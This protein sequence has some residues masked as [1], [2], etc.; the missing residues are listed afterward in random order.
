MA[1]GAARIHSC[2]D[3]LTSTSIF[4]EISFCSTD[5]QVTETSRLSFENNAG[6]LL[7][8][9]APIAFWAPALQLTNL[10][11]SLVDRSAT[12][13]VCDRSREARRIDDGVVVPLK[14]KRMG[15]VSR[16][17]HSKVPAVTLGFWIIKIAATTLG[18]TGGDAVTMTFNWGYRA[19]TIL[20]LGLLVVLVV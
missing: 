13:R 17:S 18:E 5:A 9:V 12:D 4:L 2:I 20:F 10:I 16:S 14:E 1:R 6:D 15:G 3:H 19:G 11:S 7:R 8:A